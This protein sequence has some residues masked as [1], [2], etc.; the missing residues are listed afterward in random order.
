M[1]KTNAQLSAQAWQLYKQKL[2]L[3]LATACIVLLSGGALGVLLS[4]QPNLVLDKA[5]LFIQTIIT[6]TL[7][8]G[9]KGLYWQIACG[10]KPSLKWLIAYF[11]V[12]SLPF[13]L[14]T[15]TIAWG[16]GLLSEA[17]VLGIVLT[18]VW[19]A[20]NFLLQFMYISS[21]APHGLMNLFREA[22]AYMKENRGMFVRFFLRM[23]AYMMIM[24]LLFV[25]LFA[26]VVMWLNNNVSISLLTIVLLLIC[27]IPFEPFVGI[28]SA[29][30]VKEIMEH[31]KA[32]A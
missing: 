12:K 20:I 5:L 8:L 17:P 7:S 24:G 1:R 21:G 15:G 27:S 30:F 10:E 13:I 23:A 4:Y 2:G 19:M 28:F 29:L 18:F 14:M 11:N 32:K 26:I 16:V 22:L 3:C 25:I 31:T 6:T 9:G